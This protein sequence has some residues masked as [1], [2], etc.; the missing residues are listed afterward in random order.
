MYKGCYKSRRRL[1]CSTRKKLKILFWWIW[2]SPHSSPWT[3]ASSF[4]SWV[5]LLGFCPRRRRSSSFPPLQTRAQCKL[6]T[7]RSDCMTPATVEN[8]ASRLTQTEPR[9]WEKTGIRHIDIC[10]SNWMQSQKCMAMT[11]TWDSATRSTS[12][13]PKIVSVTT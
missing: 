6:T 1:H 11:C 8:T 9:N 7:G 2:P 10:I 5:R 12:K 3:S 4:S 13:P